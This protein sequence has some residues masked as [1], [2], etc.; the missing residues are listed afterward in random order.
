MELTVYDVILGPVVSY[1]AYKLNQKLKKL[2]LK[3]H[4]QANKTLVAEALRK[5]FNVQVESVAVLIRKGKSKRIRK[6]NTKTSGSLEKRA[7]V[8]LAEGYSLDLFSQAQTEAPIQEQ[9][10]KKS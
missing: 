7:I 6:T 9:S 1:K 5:L 10:E 4:P 2:V 3:I 8:T